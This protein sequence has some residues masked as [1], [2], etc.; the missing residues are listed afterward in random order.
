MSLPRDYHVI[1]RLRTEPPGQTRCYPISA[2][3]GLPASLPL[4]SGT[5]RTGILCLRIVLLIRCSM[6]RWNSAVQVAHKG[7][8]SQ[9]AKLQAA[10]QCWSAPP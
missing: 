7:P 1:K 5:A 8:Q 6:R 9:P 2:F 4:L 10:R 3:R